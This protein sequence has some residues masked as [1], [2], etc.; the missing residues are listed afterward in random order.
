VRDALWNE[1]EILLRSYF[2]YWSGTGE[3]EPE[4]NIYRRA[5]IAHTGSDMMYE[6]QNQKFHCV[7]KALHK[8]LNIPPKNKRII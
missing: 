1:E 7:A 4:S 5:L 3:H 8:N 6:L 2:P